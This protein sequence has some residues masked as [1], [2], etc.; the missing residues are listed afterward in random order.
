MTKWTAQN[1]EGYETVPG[2]T[3]DVAIFAIDDDGVLRVLLTQRTAEPQKDA[4]ALPG[5]FLGATETAEE[6]ADRKLFEKTG[7]HAPRLRLVGFYTAVDRDQRGRI[8]SSLYAAMLPKLVEPADAGN[9]P[10]QW[11]VVED[12]LTGGLDLAFDHD[13]MVRD[14]VTVAADSKMWRDLLPETFTLRQAH[15]AYTAVNRRNVDF[16]NFR[17]HLKKTGEVVGTGETTTGH[18]GPAA[19]LFRWSDTERDI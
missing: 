7:M 8:P 4:W 15:D 17:R 9:A 19:E 18:P 1:S 10:H 12:I 11:A 3:T 6:N 13:Q 16:A 5:G 14:A 2:I